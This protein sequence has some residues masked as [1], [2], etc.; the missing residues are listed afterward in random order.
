MSPKKLYE[1]YMR[2]KLQQPPPP[3]YPPHQS[4]MQPVSLDQKVILAKFVIV[5]FL[6]F[7]FN[8][9]VLTCPGTCCGRTCFVWTCCVWTWILG[10]EGWL[11][12]DLLPK[13]VC[14]KIY[15]WGMGL[16]NL[17]I[18]TR[19]WTSRLFQIVFFWGVYGVCVKL[20]SGK[21]LL[22]LFL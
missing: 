20:F 16:I 7:V 3:S 6:V 8:Q 11:G 2:S 19:P 9:F 10:E 14:K 21:G 22:N 13:D 18:I 17:F 4:H 5:V 1:N 12:R 15:F